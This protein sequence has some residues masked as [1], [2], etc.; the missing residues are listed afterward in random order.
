[1]KLAMTY[2][3]AKEKADPTN[4]KGIEDERLASTKYHNHMQIGEEMA[5][6]WVS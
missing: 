5:E 2:E 4:M 3:D 1:M 6:V